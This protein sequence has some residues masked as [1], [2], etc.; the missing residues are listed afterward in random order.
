MTVLPLMAQSRFA[1]SI[2]AHDERVARHRALDVERSR[3]RIAALRAAL[4][5][6][7]RST[8][9]AA[10]GLDRVARRGMQGGRH[11]RT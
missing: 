11:G 1:G 8:G 9:I 7:I 3:L 5:L 10:P 4:P 2:Q 6:G